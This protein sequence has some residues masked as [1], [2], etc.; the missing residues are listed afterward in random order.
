MYWMRHPQHGEGPVEVM[1]EVKLREAS[2][3]ELVPYPQP[4]QNPLEPQQ[5]V[6]A[7]PPGEQAEAAAPP[8]DIFGGDDPD[9]E[10]ERDTQPAPPASL[11]R[12]KK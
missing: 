4:A 11:G 3:W 8:A 1:D 9:S 6:Q 2:G 10:P 7:V 5:A 12:R